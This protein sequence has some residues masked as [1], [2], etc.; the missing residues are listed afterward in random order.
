M[1]ID[2]IPW[3]KNHEYNTFTQTIFQE[4]ILH[5]YTRIH[6]VKHRN[7]E[8]KT[9]A[10]ERR[11]NHS[12]RTINTTQQIIIY[13]N[14]LRLS[15]PDSRLRGIVNSIT[16][17]MHS[18]NSIMCSY[19][20]YNVC[21]FILRSLCKSVVKISYDNIALPFVTLTLIPITYIQ[22]P[23]V[24]H[25]DIPNGSSTSLLHRCMAL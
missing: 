24:I 18:H 12:I 20:I 14:N 5:S 23:S 8:T 15:I 4:C 7:D 16:D 21:F 2:I 10:V 11:P 3:S 22:K 17:L 25:E 19:F 1:L 13:K 9:S 6:H